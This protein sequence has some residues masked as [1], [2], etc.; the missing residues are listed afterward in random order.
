MASTQTSGITNQIPPGKALDSVFGT[1]SPTESSTLQQQP[2]NNIPL[3]FQSK[4][5]GY[6]EQLNNAKY[7]YPMGIVVAILI[8]ITIIW[9]SKGMSTASKLI[10]TMFLV[11][12]IVLLVAMIKK[13]AV[14]I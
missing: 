3:A 2:Q 14:V 5:K 9:F 1:D 4:L 7:L 11:I 6:M 8:S 13:Q 10:S 12:A